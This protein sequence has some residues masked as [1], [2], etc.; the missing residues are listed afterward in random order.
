[1]FCFRRT[2]SPV[3]PSSTNWVGG[4]RTPEGEKRTAR[5]ERR[6]CQPLTNSPDDAYSAVRRQAILQLSG[7]I[8][9]FQQPPI[10]SKS[11]VAETTPG[12]LSVERSCGAAPQLQVPPVARPRNQDHPRGFAPRTPLHALS[13]QP[14]RWCRWR[15]VGAPFAWAH[16]L[17]AFAA[18]T[19]RCPSH[20]PTVSLA[21]SRSIRSRGSVATLP[22]VV[23]PAL[24]RRRFARLSVRCPQF[25]SHTRR[26]HFRS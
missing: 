16:A 3:G 25:F 5:R 19:G 4:F 15:S 20:S 1:V 24:G 23:I 12:D 10:S 8:V 17:R 2:D 9:S 26:V 14:R 21:L 6:E 13:L 7:G 18:V 22:R 11:Q